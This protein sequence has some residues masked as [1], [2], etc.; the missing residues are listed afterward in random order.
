MEEKKGGG[1]WRKPR[2][3]RWVESTGGC[4]SQLPLPCKYNTWSG[5]NNRNISQSGGRKV[6]DQGT[7]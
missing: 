6:K 4:V 1:L 7:G 2:Q 3:G 5:V